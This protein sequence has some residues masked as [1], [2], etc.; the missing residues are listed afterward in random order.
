MAGVKDAFLAQKN[1]PPQSP[2]LNPLDISIW[3][4]VEG[5]ACKC[6]H[7]NEDELKASVD[8]VWASMRKD[9]VRKVCRE[10]RPRLNRVI[11]AKGCHIE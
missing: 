11:E 10:F 4:H 1:W 6:R 5:K 8:C 2:D 7:S 3:T 9:Y